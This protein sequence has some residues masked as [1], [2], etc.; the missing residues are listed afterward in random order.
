MTEKESQAMPRMPKTAVILIAGFFF[1]P[2]F[3]LF[4]PWDLAMSGEYRSP[5]LAYTTPLFFMAA[6][7]NYFPAVIADAL[8]PLPNVKIFY[9]G[10]FCQSLLLTAAMLLLLRA[11]LYYRWRQLNPRRSNESNVA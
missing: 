1:L 6:F 3:G 9:I 11:L 8:R 10:A 2:F 7:A 5:H 4:L